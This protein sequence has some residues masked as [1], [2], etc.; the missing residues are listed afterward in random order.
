[1]AWS[2]SVLLPDSPG[3]DSASFSLTGPGGLRP[4]LPSTRQALTGSGGLTAAVL[5]RVCPKGRDAGAPLTG[6][7]RPPD[8]LAPG[9]RGEARTLWR[10][11]RPRARQHAATAVPGLRVAVPKTRVTAGNHRLREAGTAARRSAPR[12]RQRSRAKEDAAGRRHGR[13]PSPAHSLLR[14]WWLPARRVSRS[15]SSAFRVFSSRSL[16][17]AEARHWRAER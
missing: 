7:G 17:Q 4:L 6:S 11:P 12:P 5:S 8:N 14:P 9:W 3:R 1:V 15:R 10:F 2:V 13:G 16:A